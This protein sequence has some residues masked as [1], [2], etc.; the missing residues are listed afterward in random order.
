MEFLTIFIK[1]INTCR[2]FI[3]IVENN[4]IKE[5]KYSNIIVSKIKNDLED[6]QMI[7]PVTLVVVYI[8]IDNFI[9]NKSCNKYRSILYLCDFSYVKEKLM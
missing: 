6:T 8:Y 2:K 1:N 3:E 9:N 7:M 4:L 5:I